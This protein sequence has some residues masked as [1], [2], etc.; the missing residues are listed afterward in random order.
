MPD[1]AWYEAAYRGRDSAV[2]PLEPGHVFFLNDPLGPKKGRLLDIGCGTGNFLAAARDAGFDV[3]GLEPNQN[4][5]RF[6]EQQYGLKRIFA[7]APEDFEQSHDG[8]RF[9]VVTFFEVLE[10][11][12]HPQNFLD[13]AKSFLADDGYIALSVPNRTRWQVGIDTL[14]YPPN[15]LTRWSP[16]ALRK[17]LERNNFKVLTLRAEEL[18]ARRATQMLNAFFRTGMVSRV[19]GENPPALADLANMSAARVHETLDGVQDNPRRGAVEQL[20]IWKARLL[21]P[22]AY[23]LLPFLRMRGFTGLYMY[24]LAKRKPGSATASTEMNS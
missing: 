3:I 22:L 9:D 24:C 20:V 23:V 19:A 12:E 11:Q 13:T 1:A 7:G 5:V 18:N 8:E 16:R 14:D 6:A 2:M 21:K 10:H 15:H 4:A 17:F